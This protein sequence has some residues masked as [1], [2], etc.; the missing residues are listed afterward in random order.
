MRI[1]G[2]NKKCLK[3]IIGTLHFLLPINNFP[4]RSDCS[5]KKN[6]AEINPSV[7]G[8]TVALTRWAKFN[9]HFKIA[10]KDVK[11]YVIN[12]TTIPTVDGKKSR[13][14]LKYPKSNNSF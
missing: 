2:R 3:N 7:C 13:R 9:Q 8:S 1:M 14:N 5:E 4:S 10:K 11:K 6:L 12:K